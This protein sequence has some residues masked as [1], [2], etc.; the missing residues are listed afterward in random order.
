MSN[1]PE[2]IRRDIETTR[3]NLSRDV[4]QLTESVRPS[5]VARRQVDKVTGAASGMKDKVMGAA[6]DLQSSGGDSMSQAGDAASSVQTKARRQTKGN[7]LAAG[8][9]AF[10]AGAL[11]G[12]LMPASEKEQQAAVALKEK[13]QPVVE[14]AKGVAQD[15]AQNLKPQA[16]EAA[17]SVKEQATGSAEKVKQ[18]GQS[19]AQDVKGSAQD[20][21]DTVQESRDS[22]STGTIGGSGSGSQL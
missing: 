3:S 16:Q 14:E 4:D 22:S 1:D 15:A 13:A 18:E 5:N 7:P 20:A 10:G 12:S 19:A 9:I 11:L 2:Q 21:K 6:S 17:E 8:L